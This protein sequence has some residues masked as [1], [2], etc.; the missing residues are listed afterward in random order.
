MKG[1]VG[2]LIV[3]AALAAPALA[4]DMPVKAR[5]APVVAAYDWSGFYVGVHGG[6]GW[7]D[8]G[9]TMPGFAG[10]SEYDSTGFVG[11]G[12]VGINW[13]FNRLVLGVEGVLNLNTTEDSAV[14]PNAALRCEND[15]DH[16][17]RVGGRVGVTDVL[18]NNTLIY[19]MAGFARAKVDSRLVTGGGVE[20]ATASRHHH[21]AYF[22]AGIEY[23]VTPNFIIGLEGYHVSLGDKQH[24]TPNGA[25]IPGLTRDVDLDFSVVQARASYK[26]NWG[27][28]VVARY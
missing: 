28:P 3:S 22:G 7:G 5:P 14:C 20:F 27:G 16:F 17:W 24:F 26:F 19:G 2:S 4:A 10:V 12:H 9:F 6:Y 18:S 23:A 1:F 15:I 25:V 11:G 21:G 13:Q 8:V